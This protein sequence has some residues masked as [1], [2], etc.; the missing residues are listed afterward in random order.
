MMASRMGSVAMMQALLNA[1]ADV[2]KRSTGGGISA[3]A[4]AAAARNPDAVALLLKFNANVNTDTQAGAVS[5]LVQLVLGHAPAMCGCGAATG[6]TI[7]YGMPN[8][9]NPLPGEGRLQNNSDHA[10]KRTDAVLKSLL[11]G[12]IAIDVPSGRAHFSAL[13]LAVALADA[14]MVCSCAVS[15]GT[16]HAAWLC[17]SPGICVCRLSLGCTSQS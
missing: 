12:G 13:E 2:H 5:P 4:L 10:Y 1:R 7:C 3:L 11:K 14:P 9:V 16:E 17:S 8:L 15:S 6:C